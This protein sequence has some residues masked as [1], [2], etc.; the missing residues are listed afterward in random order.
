MKV[1][2]SE[3]E[4]MIRDLIAR[5]KAPLQTALQAANMSIVRMIKCTFNR[6]CFILQC[7]D[8]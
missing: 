2:R 8:T 5:V 4:D 1:S 3:L 7:F 6:R